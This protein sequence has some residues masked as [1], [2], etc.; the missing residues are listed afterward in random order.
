AAAHRAGIVHRDIKPE[1]VFLAG[2]DG[3][4]RVKLLDFG[5]AKPLGAEGGVTRTG[6]MVGTPA[7]MPPEQVHGEEVDTRADVYSFA[8]VCYEALAGRAAIGGEHLGRVLVN[9]VGAEP[10]KL[11]TLRPGVPT[12][13]DEA[14][15]SALAKDRARR[16]ADIEVWAASFV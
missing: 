16:H 13:V 15:A 8:A 11:S 2:E 4:F 7:Y 3:G 9:V 5:I 6:M 1:N 14:I 10:P 12:V